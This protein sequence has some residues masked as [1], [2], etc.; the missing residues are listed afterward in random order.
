MLERCQRSEVALGAAEPYRFP[1]NALDAFVTF[2]ADLIAQHL[3]EHPPEV[4]GFL[5]QRAAF[6]FRFWQHDRPVDL[7]QC[8]V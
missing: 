6:P 8:Q 3:P 2:D 5:A 7:D 1:P 4:A